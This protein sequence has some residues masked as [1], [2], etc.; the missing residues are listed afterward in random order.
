MLAKIQFKTSEIINLYTHKDK[1][2]ESSVIRNEDRI[3]IFTENELK[4]LKSVLDTDIKTI[5]I[6]EYSIIESDL[7][8]R[9]YKND[10]KKDEEGMK[11]FNNYNSSKGF[12]LYC[13]NYQKYGYNPTFIVDLELFISVTDKFLT[14]VPFEVLGIIK[15]KESFIKSSEIDVLKKLISLERKLSNI[16]KIQNN[17]DFNIKVSD[18]GYLDIKEVDVLENACT[19]ELQEWID[20]GWKIL[21]IC[22]QGGNRRPDYIL[23]R[24]EKISGRKRRYIE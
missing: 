17:L 24:N 22:P 20:K 5:E 6:K 9:N 14:S 21:N 4:E 1:I 18:L 12:N 11:T 2:I 15:T 23:G 7:L 10:V 19:D 8:N 13:L 3:N 16:D